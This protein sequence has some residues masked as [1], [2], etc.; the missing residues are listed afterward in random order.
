[1]L[2]VIIL[3]AGDGKRMKSKLIKVAHKCA[4]APVLEWVYSS[5][6]QIKE[7]INPIVVIG[8][9][10]DKVKEILGDKVKYAVQEERLG[11]GHA[12]MQA[13]PYL[14][15]DLTLVLSGDSPLITTKT[16]E[17]AIKSHMVQ[18]ANITL[19]RA[20]LRNPFGYGRIVRNN[21]QIE[22]IVEE[23]D[24]TIDEKNITEVNTGIYIFDTNV[25]TSVLSSIKPNNVQGEYY[26]TDCVEIALKR[27]ETVVPY[28]LSD[29]T[30]MLGINNRMQLAQAGEILRR[31]II[32]KH[33]ENGVTI[34]D[35]KSTY[36]GKNVE[37]GIDT[38]IYPNAI[39]D[40]KTKIGEDCTIYGGRIKD[41][42]IGNNVI[43]DNSI[44]DEVIIE[45]GSNIGPFTYLRPKT[46]IGQNA[47]VGA[48]AETKN[49]HIGDGTKIPHL[50]YVGDID[51]GKNC[52]FGCGSIV[53]NYDGKKKH[54][55]TV[56]DNVFIGS[57]VN[58]VSPVNIGDCAFIAAGTTVTHDVPAE[59]LSIG[60]AKQENK[61]EWNKDGWRNKK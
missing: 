38:I 23:K 46:N 59:S 28:M 4:G 51:V 19:L 55:S 41:S 61:E 18:K 37:I 13:V 15:N 35:P 40:G 58:L 25:L 29:N 43:I 8:R 53:A 2:D 60:R 34:I 26:L 44:L 56:G 49:A 32:A 36:I 1:M 42:L 48:F 31:R 10:S 20:N 30:E 52:N 47:K 9:D 16:L 6:K 45:S 7:E 27:K 21:D 39:I 24:A 17:K 22:R 33:L 50:S 12:C 11:T 3:A 57:N 5:C 14:K 54:R